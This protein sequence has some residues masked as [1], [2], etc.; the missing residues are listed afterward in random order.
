MIQKRPKKLYNDKV[1]Y[2]PPC[3]LVR[4]VSFVDGKCPYS[5]CKSCGEC[6]ATEQDVQ[7][8]EML[9]FTR[10]EDIGLC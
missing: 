6:L 8:M 3:G 5:G 1:Q 10:L 7:A 2:Y 4:F 9:K